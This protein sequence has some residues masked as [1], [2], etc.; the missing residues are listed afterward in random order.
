MARFDLAEFWA[1]PVK[2]VTSC[3]L[4]TFLPLQCQLPP[5]NFAL[6]L[7]SPRPRYRHAGPSTTKSSSGDS[8]PLFPTTAAHQD[9]RTGSNREFACLHRLGLAFFP[10]VPTYHILKGL[11]ISKH[12]VASTW[13][14][15]PDPV[16]HI[17]IR[18]LPYQ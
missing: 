16:L 14:Q 1:K 6:S 8:Q 17:N 15:P 9:L 11:Q 13:R 18:N 3:V 5:I 2:M 10:Q 7:P 12:V 4:A